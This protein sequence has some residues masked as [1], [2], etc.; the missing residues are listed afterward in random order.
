VL[1]GGLVARTL[2][3]PLE[4]ADLVVSGG[5]IGG[6]VDRAARIDVS[7]CVVVPGFVCAH[8]HLYSTLARGMPGPADAPRN[9]LEILERVWWR[10]DRALDLE[11]IHLSALAGAVLAARC[12][13]TAIIDH[14]ASPQ[15]ID[16]SLDAIADAVEQ[17]GVRAVLCYEVSDRHGEANGRAGVEENARFSARNTR[18]LV[19]AMAGGHASFTIG[20]ATMEALVGTAR[21]SG[22]PLHIHV[23]EDAIDERDAR[24]NY[25]VPTLERLDRAGALAE[26][27]LIAHGVHLDDAELAALRVSGAWAAHNPRSNMNNAVGYAPAPRMGARVGLGTDGID[28]DMLAELRVCYLE[29]R[30]H[31]AEPDPTWSVERLGAGSSIAAAS[32]GEPSLGTLDH[33]APADLVVLD[34]HPPTPLE[35]ANLAG[36]LL[37]GVSSASVR[38]VMVGG[39]WIVRDHRHQLVDEP[40]LAARCRRAAPELWA[41]MQGL[42]IE[43]G[44]WSAR[45]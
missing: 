8:H 7:G 41:R 2:T 43:E 23:A 16:S 21:D 38:D 39:H 19:R 24:A 26:G 42:T 40:E 29:A 28:G 30:A 31:G 45:T 35:S 25:G 36:H 34:Y 37:F 3:G 13:T 22:I 27:D 5:R 17:A 1:A 11:T 9:F 32:F 44:A 33:G 12:G 14:H 6:D 15:A 4:A 18:A 20:P 10:L